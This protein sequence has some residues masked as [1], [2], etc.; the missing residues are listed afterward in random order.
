ML[1]NHE[2]IISTEMK[3]NKPALRQ[4]NRWPL[5]SEAVKK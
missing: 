1:Y 3:V 2:F 5:Q 4:K